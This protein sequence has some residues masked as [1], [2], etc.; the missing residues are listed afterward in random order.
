MAYT[1]HSTLTVSPELIFSKNF[2][3]APKFHFHRILQGLWMPGKIFSEKS[4]HKRGNGDHK[5]E[6]VF[7]QH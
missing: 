1:K 4:V 3:I 2:G 5:Y 6:Q 7:G